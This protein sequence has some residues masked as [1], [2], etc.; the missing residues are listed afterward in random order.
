M[1]CRRLVT[2]E[3]CRWAWLVGDPYQ[4]LFSWAGASASYFMGW[5]A[6]KQ[7]IMPRSYRCAPAIMQVGERCLQRLPDYW[8]RGIAPADH[9]GV[10][11]ESANYADDLED[12]RPDED[13][14][15]IARTNRNVY[16]IKAALEAMGV[17]YRY[18]KQKHSGPTVEGFRV[19]RLF[20]VP[21]GELGSWVAL[22]TDAR[23]RL[24]AGDQG[25]RG[26]VRI[27]PAP[28]DGSQPTVVERI[29]APITGAQ[30]L[31]WAFDAL[32]VV[33]NGGT[34]SGLYRVTDSDGDDMPDKVERLRTLHGGGEHGPHNVLLS[35]DGKRLVVIAGN[36]TKPPFEVRDVT[37]PQTM[38][39]IR[40]NQRR[41]EG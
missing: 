31:L 28:L 13:T 33:C 27:T 7:H 37:P 18:T 20:V 15:V 4:V 39:G 41:T 6:E 3:K 10:V 21:G 29:P 19:E 9:D 8:D 23:G 17:P 11:E 12:L 36:H 2:G 14:L 24:I 40:P 5:R 1:A 32:Y 22:T 38:G 26:L 35:P 34:G 30:G 25:G 16:S